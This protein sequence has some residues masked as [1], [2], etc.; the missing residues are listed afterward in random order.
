ML[1]S[2]GNCLECGAPATYH[3][4]LATGRVMYND[5]DSGQ[6]VRL[7]ETHKPADWARAQPLNAQHVW[8][9]WPGIVETHEQAKRQMNNEGMKTMTTTDEHQLDDLQEIRQDIELMQARFRGYRLII[10]DISK[11]M[12]YP[13]EATAVHIVKKLAAMDLLFTDGIMATRVLHKDLADRVDER[14]GK[15]E[16]H[17]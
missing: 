10:E 13:L 5:A 12:P 1:N 7:C 6:M 16:S 17:G 2:I 4:D 15:D 9:R 3:T 8:F 11:A 14:K